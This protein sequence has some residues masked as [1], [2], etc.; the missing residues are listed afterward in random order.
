MEVKFRKAVAADAATISHLSEQLGYHCDPEQTTAHLLALH[1]S[2]ND[3]VY[4]ATNKDNIVGWMHIFYAVRI[5]SA[6]FCE[7]AGLVVHENYRRNSIGRLFINL[8]NTWC[9]EKQ[10]PSLRVRCNV[11]RAAS[12]RFYERI[13]FTEVKEQK[14]YKM[15]L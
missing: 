5:E 3:A 4:V 11:L 15:E 1:D 10:C 2:K 13:G 14:V 8:A 9:R 7:I 12:H 6:P